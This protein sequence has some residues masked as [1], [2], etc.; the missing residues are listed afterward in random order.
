ML[1]LKGG[2]VFDPGRGTDR[3]AD[4]LIDRDQG[5]IKALGRNLKVAGAAVRDCRGLLVCP[6]FIDVHVHFREPGYEAKETIASGAAAAVHGGFAAVITMPNTNPSLDNETSVAYQLLR[7]REAGRARVYP[8]GCITVGR[9][10]RKMAELGI[11]ARAGA[12]AFSDDGNAVASSRALRYAFEYS[13]G[14]GRTIIEHCEDAELSEGGIIHEGLVSAALG[15]GGWPAAAEELIVARDLRLCE[16]TGGRL[17]IAHISTA[18]S[19]ELVRK[20][21]ACG[22]PVTAEVTPHH[23][24]LTDELCRSFE[25]VYRVNPPL[26]SAADVAACRAALRDGTID[27]IASDHAPHTEEEKA[28]GFVEAPNGVIGLESTIGVLL[29]ELVGKG[30]LSLSRFVEALTAAPARAFGLCGGSLEVGGPA[31]LTLL[32]LE[33]EWTLEPEQFRSKGRNCPFAG[34]K[35]KGAPVETIVAGCSHHAGPDDA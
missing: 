34:Y 19:I 12:V 27:V 14:L 2:R 25:P 16:L 33:R 8:T 21:K 30:E 17:H 35:L 11:L 29:T 9:K 5:V 22:V 13:H 3:K 31:D 24:L 15:L 20:A 23:L 28:R 1:L 10:G 26:R 6:G 18:G 7:A 32:D 4:L